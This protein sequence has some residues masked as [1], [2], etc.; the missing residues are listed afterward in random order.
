LEET[1]TIISSLGLA[2]NISD[3]ITNFPAHEGENGVGKNTLLRENT[4][5][6]YL[7]LSVF[8]YSFC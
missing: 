6:K 4:P 7:Y 8:L 2:K 3:K 1:N 5:G